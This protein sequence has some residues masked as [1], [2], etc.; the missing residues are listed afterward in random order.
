[1]A[2]RILSWLI[3]VFSSLLILFLR[4][5]SFGVRYF[6][7]LQICRPDLVGFAAQSLDVVVS[8]SQNCFPAASS[9]CNI[10][11][12]GCYHCRDNSLSL[13]THGLRGSWKDLFL[14]VRRF[15]APID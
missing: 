3:A 1:M 7:N 12:C 14:Q 8:W 13:K 11:S 2:A 6:I 10:T 9:G 15:N 5:R 4:L